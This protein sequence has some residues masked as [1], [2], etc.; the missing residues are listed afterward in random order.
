MITDPIADMLTRIRNAQMV[1]KQEVL[2]PYSKFKFEIAKILKHE[3]YIVSV[4]KIEEAKFPSLKI[5]L[6]YDEANQPIINSIKRVSKPGQ[7]VYVSKNNIASI[8]NNFGIAILSTSSGIMTSK[9]AKKKGIGGE[10]ICEIW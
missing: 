1:K 5:V 9:D 4:E 2:I 7:R 3:D 8:L 10:I 6:K